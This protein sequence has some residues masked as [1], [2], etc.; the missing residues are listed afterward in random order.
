MGSV[1]F[2]ILSFL[3]AGSNTAAAQG[4]DSWQL[5]PELVGDGFAFRARWEA[6]FSSCG[7]PMLFDALAVPFVSRPLL[8]HAGPTAKFRDAWLS[9][10]QPGWFLSGVLGWFEVILNLECVKPAA[11]ANGLFHA[12]LGN[13]PRT[14]SPSTSAFTL[15][16]PSFHPC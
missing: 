9:T 4:S 2:F 7:W 11:I 1:A 12:D 8:E 16:C 14:H 13:C 10:S 5:Q 3:H 6:G 15:C